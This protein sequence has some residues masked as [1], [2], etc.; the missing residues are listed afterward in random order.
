MEKR[1]TLHYV[2]D[3]FCGWCYGL[4]PPVSVAAE[5]HGPDVVPHSGGMLA[6]KEAKMMSPEW[7]DF[8]RPPTTDQRPDWPVATAACRASALRAHGIETLA[9]LTVRMPRRRR[10]WAI[11][12]GLGPASAR[13]V[14][15]FFAQHPRLT[16]RAH[17]PIAVVD[18]GVIVPW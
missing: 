6:G 18:C 5:I 2:Y 4:A 8:V 16:A 1:A 17:A 10:W 11:V 9:D 3:P 15:D 14:E 13:Q 12:S 7:R